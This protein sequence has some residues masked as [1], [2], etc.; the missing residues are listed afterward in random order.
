M[1]D[2]NVVYVFKKRVKFPY[3]I[4]FL[5]QVSTV[6]HQETVDRLQCFISE[7]KSNVSC[8]VHFE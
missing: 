8:N 2:K 1:F 6:W 7:I 3:Y 5:K 4:C